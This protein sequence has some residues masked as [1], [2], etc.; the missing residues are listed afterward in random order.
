MIE[1]FFTDNDYQLR[2]VYSHHREVTKD[3]II[4]QAKK[5]FGRNIDILTVVGYYKDAYRDQR[6]QYK[7]AISTRYEPGE[8]VLLWP[9]HINELELPEGL[10]G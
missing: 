1:V 9:K 4:S 8:A 10:N 6:T 3:R 5:L 2:S 7:N